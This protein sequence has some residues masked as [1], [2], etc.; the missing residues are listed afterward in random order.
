MAVADDRAHCIAIHWH[1]VDRLAMGSYCG[2]LFDLRGLAAL[3]IAAVIE[4]KLGV[5]TW[6]QGIGMRW[7]LYCRVAERAPPGASA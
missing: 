1:F 3:E 5:D 7:E 4:Q 6:G 2:E